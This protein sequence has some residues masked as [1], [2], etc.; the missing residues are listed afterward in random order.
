MQ[1]RKCEIPC[2]TATCEIFI[3]RKLELTWYIY[4]TVIVQPQELRHYEVVLYLRYRLLG[5]NDSVSGSVFK[6]TFCLLR[7]HRSVYSLYIGPWRYIYLSTS[8][9]GK[10]VA[11]SRIYQLQTSQP[12][13]IT[14]TLHILHIIQ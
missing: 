5:K 11:S 12:Y 1:N 4:S 2:Q 14:Y 7:P 9:L 8:W 10:Y 13:Y 3:L 6:R